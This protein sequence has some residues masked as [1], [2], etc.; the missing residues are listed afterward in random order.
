MENGTTL[1][2]DLPGLALQNSNGSRA[3]RGWCMWSP[4]IRRL[5]RAQSAARSRVQP[6]RV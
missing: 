4:M 3:A 2:L 6:R 5:R 1:L